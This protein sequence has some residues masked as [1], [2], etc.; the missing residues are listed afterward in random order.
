MKHRSPAFLLFLLC[1]SPILAPPHPAPAAEPP[2]GP[3][4]AGFIDLRQVLLR[5]PLMREFDLRSRRFQNSA[6]AWVADPEEARARYQ[7]EIAQLEAQ[8][9]NL[10]QQVKGTPG[11]PGL[12]RPTPQIKET[13]DRLSEIRVRIAALKE[14]IEATRLAGTYLHGAGT[15][16]ESLAPI[17]QTIVRD[18]RTMVRALTARHGNLP[19]LD[20]ACFQPAAPEPPPDRNL[21]FQNLQGVIWQGNPDPRLLQAWLREFRRFLRQEQPDR[22]SHPFRHGFLDLRQ[23]AVSSLQ[24]GTP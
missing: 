15:G 17:I 19:I 8:Q 16:V 2:S 22:F 21:L 20:L 24:F 9:R 12:A 23:E 6:S 10:V 3:A 1:F 7:G 11:T 14:A 4:V 13:W 18:V 5:H